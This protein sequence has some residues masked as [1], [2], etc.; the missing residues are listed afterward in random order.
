MQ[1]LQF[2]PKKEKRD[3]IANETMKI[4][5]PI[6]KRLGLYHYQVILENACFK[7]L[8]PEDFEKICVYLRKQFSSTDK[9][10]KR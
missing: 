3:N 1:T 8:Y 2:H 7:N 10:I 4:Y 5:V 9:Q 6:A